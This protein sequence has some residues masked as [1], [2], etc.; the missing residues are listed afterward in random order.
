MGQ[1]AISADEEREDIVE[2]LNE[3]VVLQY[4]SAHRLDNINTWLV[5]FGVLIALS[6][7]GSIIGLMAIVSTINNQ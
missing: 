7:V 5:L 6:T 2:L 1:E 4:R 3:I